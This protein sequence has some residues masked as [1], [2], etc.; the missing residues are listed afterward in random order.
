MNFFII[1]KTSCGRKEKHFNCI[2]SET[3][4]IRK[5]FMQLNPCWLYTQE[6]YYNMDPDQ[7]SKTSPLIMNCV[8]SM[9]VSS[10]VK[11][12]NKVFQHPI[13]KTEGN[14]CSRSVK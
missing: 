3:N 13:K 6:S 12:N 7:R 14:L 9:C 5:C 4:S 2:I 10:I 8:L 11:T 1:V